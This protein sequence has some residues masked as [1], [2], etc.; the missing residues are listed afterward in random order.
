MNKKDEIREYN[1]SNLD[2]FL[3]TMFAPADAL[4]DIPRVRYLFTNRPPI[5]QPYFNRLNATTIHE[6][7][8]AIV[9]GKIQKTKKMIESKQRH[10]EISKRLEEI[11]KKTICGRIRLWVVK[12]K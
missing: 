11:C 12:R 2:T 3:V 9:Y 1:L 10:G 4:I 5:H 7:Y 8:K 6:K